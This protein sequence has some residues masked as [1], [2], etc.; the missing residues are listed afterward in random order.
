MGFNFGGFAARIPT[1]AA[2]ISITAKGSNTSTMMRMTMR[3]DF[4]SWL[5]SAF[6]YASSAMYFRGPT[7][8]SARLTSVSSLI[9]CWL[10]FDTISMWDCFFKASESRVFRCPSAALR[11]L[12]AWPLS[13][14]L[15]MAASICAICLSRS[16]MDL[17]SKDS[18]LSITLT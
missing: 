11:E 1:L 6:S 4:S 3:T 10:R 13:V 14:S 5:L 17:F 9:F 12:F 16:A 7:S 8:A 18:L 2:I 15:S